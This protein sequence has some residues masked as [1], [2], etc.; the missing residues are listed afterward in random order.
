MQGSLPG[1]TRWTSAA[2]G[3]GRRAQ[4]WELTRGF[5][6]P[7]IGLFL[8]LDRLV[9]GDAQR[10]RGALRLPARARR[11]AV[12]G[13]DGVR[14]VWHPVDVRRPRR[15]APTRPAPPVPLKTPPAL[16]PA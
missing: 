9:V 1:S 12:P 5:W 8:P 3:E 11:V 7:A 2:I 6:V 14:A 16:T 13:S 10:L 15:C 4:E